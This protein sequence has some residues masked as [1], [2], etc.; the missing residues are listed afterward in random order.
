MATYRTHTCGE[1]RRA[2]CGQ[3]V[4]LQGWVHRVRDLGGVTFF[5]IRDRHGLTQVVVRADGDTATAAKLRPE[6][7]V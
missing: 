4:L 2:D 6:G 5:D 7:V 3:T 1:L